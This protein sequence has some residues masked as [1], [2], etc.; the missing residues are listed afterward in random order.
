MTAQEA[1]GRNITAERGR[2]GMTQPDL[3]RAMKAFGHDWT[4]SIVS[5]VESGMRQRM[6]VD[7]LYA[8]ALILGCR[9]P[10]LLTQ[11]AGEDMEIGPSL[12]MPAGTVAEWLRG[13]RVLVQTF[14]PD[15][16]L[17]RLKVVDDTTHT[18]DALIGEEES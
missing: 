1:L 2:R 9:F 5:Q 11:A 14:A 6:G 12:R 7:E 10:D 8:L 16:T 13:R 3:A 4:V 17:L 18:A 15:G